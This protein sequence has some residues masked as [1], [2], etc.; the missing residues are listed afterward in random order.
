INWAM[1]FPWHLSPTLIFC[2]LLLGFSLEFLLHAL[3]NNKN[4]INLLFF[5]ITAIL[6]AATIFVNQ[7]N[8]AKIMQSE[9][10]AFQLLHNAI[11]QPPNIKDQL[12]QSS[13]LV[14][15]DS[16]LHSNYVLGSA[17]YTFSSLGNFDFDGLKHL[18]N[19]SVI[20]F[21]PIYNGTLFKWAYLMPD[22]QE[23][24][25]PF[26][27]SQMNKVPDVILYNWLQHSDN[28]F[29]LGYDESSKWIDKTAAFKKK[30]FAEK[31]RRFLTVHQYMPI[32]ATVL[33]GATVYTKNIPYPDPQLCQ[34]EC[35]Q[36]A[37]CKGFTYQY[38]DH[39]SKSTIRCQFYDK[40]TQN[41]QKFC[42]TCISFVKE[43]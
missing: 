5:A 30:L 35:D 17:G 36:N 22:L 20:K 4:I 21:E 38:D 11:T 28:I 8:I 25:Y 19:F 3:I 23:E 39:Y 1:A 41:N 10:F 6:S 32:A 31:K 34:W 24:L 14:V 18:Q 15:E 9:G 33:K 7:S 27:I 13:V 16:I 29:C 43:V 26:K 42:A 37:Q 12:N 40:L 2:A